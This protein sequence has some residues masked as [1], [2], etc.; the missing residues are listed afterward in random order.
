[1]QAVEVQGT[2][3]EG[4]EPVR[5][6]FQCNF[7]QGAEVGAGLAVYQNGQPVVDL[8]AGEADPAT[9]RPWQHDTIA[10]LAS[11]TKSLAA[12]ALLLLV[13]RGD[14]DLDEP[15]ARY[16]PGFA[17]NGKGDISVRV[18]LS[19]RAGLP[20][21]HT[22]PVT[23]EDLRDWTPITE[24]LAAATPEW[25]PGTAHGYH[26]V[27][28][29]HLVGEIVR[30]VSGVSLG[31]Y[32]AREIAVPLGLDCFI[33][34][35]DAELP[36]LATMVVPDA[37]QLMLGMKVPELANMVRALN[38]PTTL[39]YRS[40]YGSVAISW[41]ATN[42]PRTYQVESP[43]MD[44]VASATSLAR[45]YAA[46]IGEVDGVRLLA[47]SLMEQ[48]RHPYG[49]GLDEILQVHTSWGLGFALP[50]G[51]MWPAP[52]Q[53]EGLFGHSGASGSFAFADPD[54]GLAFAYVPN[55]GSELLEGGD[56]RVRSLIAALYDGRV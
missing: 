11:T 22:R 9:H 48:V 46:L 56:F 3:A 37:E 10:V 16:W 7:E 31:E 2:V 13:E 17:Q 41:D 19:H 15:V 55:R 25:P 36:R 38:D 50:G 47:P 12:G 51:P 21:M 44:G 40:M 24:T 49:D 28:F 8:W 14:V 6:A 26:G 20:S 45:Y 30:R 32:F 39:T 34:V 1:M 23:W 4:F 5:D 18:L 29:G 33:R 52:E 35:P 27:T 43:S 54:R 53:I 42:D